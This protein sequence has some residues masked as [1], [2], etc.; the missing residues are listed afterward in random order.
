MPPAHVVQDRRCRGVPAILRLRATQPRRGRLPLSIV[1]RPGTTTTRPSSPA[2]VLHIAREEGG[3]HLALVGRLDADHVASVWT[4]TLKALREAPDIPVIVDASGV[5]YADGAGMAFLVDL[6][7]QPRPPAAPVSV[8]GLDPRYQALFD[9][10]DPAHYRPRPPAPAQRVPLTEQLGR[11][12]AAIGNRAYD[13]VAFLGETAHALAHA[14]SSPRSVRWRDV[15]L[16]CQRVGADALPIVSLIAFL[17]GV[18]LAFQSAVALRQYGG[19]IYVANLVGISLLRELGPLMTAVLLAGRSGAAFAAEIGT[20][21]VNEEVDALVTMGLDPVRF[22]VVP[23][24]LAAFV[25]TPLLTL[26]ANLIGL[27]GGALVMATFDIPWVTYMRQTFGFVS[28]TDFAGGM[29]KSFVFGLIVALV[30]CLRG[31]QT[32]TGAES[33]GLST[34]SA[35]VSSLVLIVVA[36]GI[37]ALIYYYLDI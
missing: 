3:L 30:G 25:M 8:T 13:A 22:L 1:T 21:R 14:C 33:V 10:F 34:T 35:V 16:A 20:M 37:F 19:E 26:Y 18:I 11:S 23:R 27:V 29:I 4:E 28:P 32:G 17:L 7:R 36:D 15:L 5:A 9:Q 2:T 24:V 31:L 6:L 12:G